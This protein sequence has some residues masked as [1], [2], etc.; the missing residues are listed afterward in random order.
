M[1]RDPDFRKNRNPSDAAGDRDKR[2]ICIC[3]LVGRASVGDRG[4]G[5][6]HDEDDPDR[7]GILLSAVWNELGSNVRS[8]LYYHGSSDRVLLFCTEIFCA[9]FDKRR[10]ERVIR[11]Q[12]ET[13]DIG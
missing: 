13:L 7:N 1:Y 5:L 12:L 2:G 9:G 6:L 4:A 8:D 10:S 3:L 11:S